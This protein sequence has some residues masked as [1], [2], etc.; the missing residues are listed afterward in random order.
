MLLAGQAP[1]SVARGIWEDR[2]RADLGQH[3][4][5]IVEDTRDG[6][7]NDDVAEAHYVLIAFSIVLLLLLVDPPV[8]LDDEPRLRTRKIDDVRTNRMLAAKLAAVEAMVP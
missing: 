5:K 1:C 2:C 7:V 3:P 8:N 4:F 6:K